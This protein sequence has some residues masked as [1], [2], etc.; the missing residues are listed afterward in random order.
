[1]IVGILLFSNVPAYIL[2]SLGLHIVFISTSFVAKSNTICV[3]MGILLF[4]DISAYVLFYSRATHYF[5]LASFA[6]KSNIACVKMNNA[7]EV[8][9]ISRRTLCTNQMTKTIKLEIDEKLLLANL[10][11]LDKKDFDVIL[12]M[13]R[14]GH[15]HVTT[16]CHEKEVLFHWPGEEELHFFV[17]R[18]KSLPH[19]VLTLQV[20]KML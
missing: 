10:Y 1:M 8:S 15:N 13:D 5:I 9:I 3:K 14:L 16:R 2:F 18:F 17:T 7:L 20:K 11:L 6:A 4:S 19:L 12:G